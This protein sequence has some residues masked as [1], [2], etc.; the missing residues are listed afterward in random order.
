MF[1]LLF[2]CDF[3]MNAC[4]GTKTIHL[5]V[6][7]LTALIRT[8][9]TRVTSQLARTLPGT[10]IFFD[11]FC[12]DLHT[13]SAND[14]SGDESNASDNEAD[15]AAHPPVGDV[16]LPFPPLKNTPP[17]VAASRWCSANL[18]D[19]DV[20]VL[21]EDAPNSS[22]QPLG[23]EREATRS[24]GVQVMNMN[25][26]QFLR[27]FVKGE[28]AEKLGKRGELL[29]RAHMSNKVRVHMFLLSSSG[30]D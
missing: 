8:P 21:C 16:S 7:L 6:G 22:R 20:V 26:H 5:C 12:P 19:A 13:P 18:G 28:A 29:R 11:K 14:N 4:V 3:K 15:P 1:D 9:A 24:D 10:L 17:L 27:E 25:L 2:V 30:V 23:E